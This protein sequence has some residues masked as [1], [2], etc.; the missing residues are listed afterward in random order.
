MT[1]V[2]ADRLLGI[3]GGALRIGGVDGV[4]VVLTTSSTT[5][6]RFAESRIHQNVAR[7]DGEARVR[8]VVDGS[9][10]V[11]CVTNDLTP[12]AVRRTAEQARDAAAVAPRDANFAG[13]AE[14]VTE[15]PH[16]VAYDETT[17]AAT[18]AARADLVA[19]ML[20]E[21]PRA[22]Y[23]AG[24]VAT[25]ARELGV[26]N[27]LGLRAYTRSS[28]ASLRL[29]AS[30]ADST[31]YAD[32]AAVRVGDLSPEQVGERAA[33]KVASGARPHELAPGHY[34]VVLE[35]AATGELVEWLARVGFAG[36]AM[37]EG[38]SPFS[39]R[40]GERMCSPSVTIVDDATSPLLP[41]VPF[42]YEGTAKRPLPLMSEGVAVGVAHD[43]SSARL[44]GAVGSTGHALPPPNAAGGVPTHLLVAPGEHSLDAL[45]AGLERGLLVTRFHYT[46]LV[47]PTTATI[48][49]MTRDGTFLVEDGRIVR[50]VRNLRF[51]QSIVEALGDVRGVGSEAA[52]THASFLGAVRAPALALGSLSFTSATTH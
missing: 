17:A 12:D 20:A 11:V 29:L 3:A 30:G 2:L 13:L 16:A 7:I 35:S 18:P 47:H 49:G 28:L 25:N 14:P 21:L 45:V 33:R 48:T 38:R 1:T 43:R 36:K 52:L 32:Q 10:V 5:L 8:V 4:E 46:N 50:G 42:D 6:T 27:S 44:A 9:R 22:V 37:H 19:R 40:V 41:G 39:G 34:A 26:A 23:G 31:G 51:T 24:A 15:Y